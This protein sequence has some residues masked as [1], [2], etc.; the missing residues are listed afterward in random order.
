DD[1]RGAT[2][3]LRR[4]CQLAARP[5]ETRPNRAIVRSAVS[6]HDSRS[7]PLKGGAYFVM[8]VKRLQALPIVIGDHADVPAAQIGNVASA[9]RTRDRQI[10]ELGAAGIDAVNGVKGAPRV[11]GRLNICYNRSGGHV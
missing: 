3:S 7:P 11:R 1:A 4:P 10:E 8:Y 9:Q 5:R 2:R 6:R